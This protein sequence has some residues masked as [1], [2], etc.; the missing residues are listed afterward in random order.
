MQNSANRGS[1]YTKCKGALNAKGKYV[2]SLD[3][4][5]LYAIENA[6]SILYEKSEKEI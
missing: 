4:D 2:M 6:F 3:V 5:D 1:L